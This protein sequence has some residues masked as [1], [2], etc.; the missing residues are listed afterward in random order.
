MFTSL[1]LCLCLNVGAQVGHQK[2][3]IV[4]DALLW[5]QAVSN[6]MQ[7]LKNK[8]PVDVYD[9]SMIQWLDPKKTTFIPQALRLK[10]LN[11][12]SPK[13]KDIIAS[14]SN[15]LSIK[16]VLTF[17][18]EHESAFIRAW[19]E[20]AVPSTVPAGIL[21]IETGYGNP[22]VIYYPALAA[23]VSLAVA[24]YAFV[25][26]SVI[27][28]LIDY[29]KV[30]YF[31]KDPEWVMDSKWHNPASPEWKERARN[32]VGQAWVQE[33]REFLNLAKLQGWDEEKAKN[34]QG[35][36]AGAVG[37]SQFLP[38]TAMKK[39]RHTGEIFDFWDWQK[40]I[41]RTSHEI[42]KKGWRK[43]PEGAI[44]G[45]NRAKWYADAVMAI[46]YK[47][48]PLWEK[49]REGLLYATKIRQPQTHQPLEN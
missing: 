2:K 32:F 44:L 38:S 4:L 23:L 14:F 33:V 1:V 18:K 24:K 36:W 46:H 9:D 42:E 34:I 21:Y 37:Y 8:R 40:A 13:E 7:E 15:A 3:E 28:Q 27:P 17:M 26:E 45:Y 31:K 12:V 25:Y 30:V 5:E 47:A 49:G 43:S 19:Q 35:S 16:R 48:Y 39:I 22:N 29:A 11:H 20:T 41:D 10:M 6:L